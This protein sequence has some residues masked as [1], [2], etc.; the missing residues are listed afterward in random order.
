MNAL[1][2]KTRTLAA[3][4]LGILTL[5]GLAA[6]AQTWNTLAPMTSLRDRLCAAT[7]PDGMVYAIGGLVGL[8]GLNTVERYDPLTTL[9]WSGA[10]PLPVPL[11]DAAAVTGQDGHIYV[12]GGAQG[13]TSKKTLYRYNTLTGQWT[14]TGQLA[15]MT[16]PR[17]YLAAA[18]DNQGRIYAIGGY[19]GSN[20]VLNT[21]EW[22]DT[23]NNQWNPAPPLNYAR[24]GHRAVT[25]QDGKIYV[26]GDFPANFEEFDANAYNGN[27]GAVWGDN[28]PP[29]AGNIENGSAAAI[30]PNGQIFSIGSNFPALTA[31]NG[32]SR[33]A[34]W[35]SNNSP[36]ATLLSSTQWMNKKRGGLAATTAEGKVFA[37]GGYNKTP[38]GTLN[39]AEAF[40]NFCAPN[41]KPCNRLWYRF[42]ESPTIFS[43]LWN[44]GSATPAVAITG[45]PNRVPGRVGKALRFDG[46]THISVP[47]NNVPAIGTGGFSIELWVRPDVTA[48][49]S[50]VVELVD[51]RNAANNW[52]GYHLFL[53]RSNTS[54][55]FSLG[56]Q[57]ND[58]GSYNNYIG[59][60]ATAQIWPGQW[61]HVAASVERNGSTTTSTLYVNAA[62]VNTWTTSA[63]TNAN[64]TC[65]PLLFGKHP[66]WGTYFVGEM[67]EV[68]LYNCALNW[69][70]ILAIFRAG[71]LGKAPS[72]FKGQVLPEDA[73]LREGLFVEM[74]FQSPLR[75][76]AI[77]RKVPLAADGAF[78][79]SDLEPDTYLVRIKGDRWLSRTLRIDLT[80]EDIVVT[81][82][83]IRLRGGDANN[84][85]IV[86]VYDLSVLIQ[87]FDLSAGVAGFI[88]GADLNNDGLVDVYDLALLIR[89]FDSEGE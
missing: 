43:M 39:T 44:S 19:N 27:T 84:D 28:G 59:L 14:T 5:T 35:T 89:N 34:P 58:G 61:A 24:Q 7:G 45:N 77:A 36:D 13:N 18:V 31:W 30:A 46:T 76:D 48:N 79:I 20:G 86:D 8:S 15:D 74:H 17:A 87:S 47:A 83:G 63:Y 51:N 66:D 49:Q 16:T 38:D 26:F 64:M 21:V 56:L 42:E 81:E 82:D 12:L 11:T 68:T 88:P 3:L 67:D 50:G 22:Y 55:P 54:A 57:L 85:N 2:W 80:Q 32:V 41:F 78:E 60:P 52:R 62:K 73:V 25:G 9:A 72:L 23:V 37:L 53:Y 75:P 29:N 65:G 70:Q 40:G 4:T 71:A 69:Q 10:P 33:V 6:H 1:P